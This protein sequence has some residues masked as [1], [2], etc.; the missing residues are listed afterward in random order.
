MAEM[1]EMSIA[2]IMQQDQYCERRLPMACVHLR[3]L[4]K[5]EHIAHQITT[6]EINISLIHLLPYTQGRKLKFIVLSAS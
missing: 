4:I 3:Q 5:H 1:V 2:A 6:E